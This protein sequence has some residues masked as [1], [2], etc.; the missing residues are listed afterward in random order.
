MLITCLRGN[1][2][3]NDPEIKVI[4]TEFYLKAF[5]NK[6]VINILTCLHEVFVVQTKVTS[7]YEMDNHP[8]R[9]A[10]L[11]GDSSYFILICSYKDTAADLRSRSQTLNF[12]HI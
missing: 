7:A 6:Y 1:K 10:M 2:I 11:S 5:L 9:R 3:L 8:Y 12:V 4:D